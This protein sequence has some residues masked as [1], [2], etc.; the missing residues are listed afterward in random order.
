MLL[1]AGSN[2]YDAC[3]GFKN[4][5]QCVAAVHVSHNLNIP[6]ADLKARMTDSTSGMTPGSTVRTTPMSLGQA[7]QS[8]RGVTGTLD[9]GILSPAKIEKEVKKAEDAAYIDLRLSRETR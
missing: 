8:F 4:W 9:A 5:G 1:P 7:I 3:R 2:I 6:F